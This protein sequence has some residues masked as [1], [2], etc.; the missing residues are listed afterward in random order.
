MLKI[1]KPRLLRIGN[2]K[3]LTKGDRGVGLEIAT[4]HEEQ[5]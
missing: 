5:G 3:R 2:A 1:F 4:F